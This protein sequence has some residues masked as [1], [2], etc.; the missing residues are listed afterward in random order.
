[1]EILKF[2]KWQWNKFEFWQKTFVLSMALMILSLMFE[3]PYNFIIWIFS[4]SIFSAWIL[5]WTLVDGIK[6][7]Y[8]NYKKEKANLFKNIK[9]SDK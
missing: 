1:M 8:R 7:S 5:K 9:E 2:I 6:N 4:V 3:H